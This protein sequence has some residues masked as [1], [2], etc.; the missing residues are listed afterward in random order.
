MYLVAGTIKLIRSQYGN[1]IVGHNGGGQD[2]VRAAL[3][4]LPDAYRPATRKAYKGH[5]Q[6]YFSFVIAYNLPHVCSEYSI[7]AF[8]EFLARGGLSPPVV[9][10]YLYFTENNVC[11]I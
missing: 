9:S 3:D 6:T 7:M 11:K 1:L 8:V 5:I 2:L 10:N 4:R